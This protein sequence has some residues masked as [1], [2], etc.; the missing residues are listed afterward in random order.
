MVGRQ[1][2]KRGICKLRITNPDMKIEFTSM[3]IQCV[4]KSKI[5]DSLLLRERINVLP[6]GSK[7]SFIHKNQ[8]FIQLIILTADGE[9]TRVRNLKAVRLCFQVFLEDGPEYL[10]VLPPIL[11]TPIFDSRSM[12]DLQIIRIS[13]CHSPVGGGQEVIILCEKV[14]VLIKMYRSIS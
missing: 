8:S 12:I 2:C 4:K 11:S 13:Q 6:F 14:Q 5:V 9:T 10:R 3:G 7:I 1:G